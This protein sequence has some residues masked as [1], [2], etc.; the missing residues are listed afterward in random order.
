LTQTDLARRTA[1][2]SETLNNLEKAES[3][4]DVDTVDKI[5]CVLERAG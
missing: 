5:I 4:P 2:R 3:T 1:I